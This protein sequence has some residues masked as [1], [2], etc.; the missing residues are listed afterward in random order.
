M[1]ASSPAQKSGASHIA[2]LL[3]LSL[4]YGAQYLDQILLGMFIQ[5]IKAEF[6]LTDTQVGLLTGLAF[7]ALFVI[8]GVPVARLADR[9]SRKLIIL[10]SATIFSIATIL[11]GVS[12]GFLSLFAMRM[13]V[14][15]GE[16]GTVPS[17]A[18]L[19]AD[20]FPSSQRRLAMS[21]HSCGAYFGTA[22][23]LLFVGLATAVLSWRHVFGIA[24]AFGLVLAVLVALFVREPERTGATAAPT[25]LLQDGRK[26]LAIRSFVFLSLAMGVISISTAA[27]I[28]WVPAFLA[29]S[30]GLDQ[31]HIVLIL[32][33]VWGIG[34]TSGG[35]ISGVVTNR[36]YRAGGK[37]PLVAVGSLAVIFPV[38]CCAAFLVTS[39]ST[40]VILFGLALFTMGG[41]RGP[42]FATVQDIVPA[43]CR[44]TANAVLMFSMYAIGVTLGPLLTGVVSDVMTA[45]LGADA[46]RYALLVVIASAGVVGAILMW[47]AAVT[48]VSPV[49]GRSEA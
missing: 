5:P 21:F 3:I 25:N 6:A 33:G 18:S 37:W 27:A 26:L 4:V 34:A 49:D 30:H 13:L 2:T 46:L 43:N 44:A 1:K 42:A 41:I 47:L 22:I 7:T 48:L 8:L 19:L 31:K 39:A 12:V 35:I 16:A 11:C 36:L 45:S 9:G 17:S 20:L 24:G 38:L 40:T 15:I 14:A 10:A 23:G 28:N 32:A 29:R